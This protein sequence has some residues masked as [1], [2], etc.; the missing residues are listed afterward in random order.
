MALLIFNLDKLIGNAK[1]W[2]DTFAETASRSGDSHL[3][4]CGR[5]D[6]YRISRLHAAGFRHASRLSQSEGHVQPLGRRGGIRRPSEAAES[7]A[8]Q[9]GTAGRRS[10]DD[11]IR[12]HA[13]AALSSRHARLSGGSGQSRVAQDKDRPARGTAR[14]FSRLRHDGEGAGAGVEVARLPGLRLGS[15]AAAE[16]GSP[17][18]SRP[19]PARAVSQSDR[20]R[21]LPVAADAG[22]RGHLLRPHLCHD[23]E[24]GDADECRARQARGGRRT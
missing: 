4:R 19:R 7:P 1:A 15:L 5:G 14:R 23:A 22:N 13:R 20:Y 17:D 9:D 3:A 11:G 16:R 8:R 6:G 10:D 21:R 24:R 18:L 2:R 12:H